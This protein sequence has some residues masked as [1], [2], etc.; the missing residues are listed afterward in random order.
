MLNGFIGWS[1]SFFGFVT[2]NIISKLHFIQYVQYASPQII[3][4]IFIK[5]SDIECIMRKNVAY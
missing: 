3:A 2:N 4:K 5:K 1:E